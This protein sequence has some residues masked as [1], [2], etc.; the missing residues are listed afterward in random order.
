MSVISPGKSRSK[1]SSWTSRTASSRW[2]KSLA[3]VDF[4]AAILPHKKINFAEEVLMFLRLARER[5]GCQHPRCSV[6]G[7]ARERR[8]YLEVQVVQVSAPAPDLLKSARASASRY[9]ALA[10]SLRQLLEQRFRKCFSGCRDAGCPRLRGARSVP[11][12]SPDSRAGAPC[13]AVPGLA[14]EAGAR[15]EKRKSAA[16]IRARRTGL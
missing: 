2:A 3:R 7:A 14:L 4:P 8:E 10:C 13:C 9:V 12:S 1:N 6:E 5:L 11:P 15:R 16:E